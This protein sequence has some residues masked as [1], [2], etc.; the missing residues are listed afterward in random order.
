[1]LNDNY[2]MKAPKR[3]APVKSPEDRKDI[4]LGIRLTAA[5]KAAIDVAANGKASAWAR[6]V[7]LRAAKRRG[8]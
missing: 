5:E 1:M 3:G 4:L 8:R 7:L 2:G 6:D